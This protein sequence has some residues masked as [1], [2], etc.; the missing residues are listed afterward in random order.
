M[1][2]DRADLNA[3]VRGLKATD[4]EAAMAGESAVMQG[5]ARI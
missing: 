3:I 1:G 2:T 5:A 4:S